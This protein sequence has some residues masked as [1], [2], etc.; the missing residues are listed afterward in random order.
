MQGEKSMRKTVVCLFILLLAV[1]LYAA[2]P[3]QLGNFPVGQW[4]DP[5][6]NVVWDFSSNNIR[7][8]STSGSVLYDFSSKTIQDFSVFMDGVQPGISFTCPEA[9]RTYRFVKTLTNTDL[10]MTI[11]RSSLPAYTVTMKKQ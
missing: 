5:N 7:I 9:G 3:I 11:E 2:D 8:L 4:L 10:I 1:S 6:Y